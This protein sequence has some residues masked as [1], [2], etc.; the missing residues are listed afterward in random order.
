[1]NDYNSKEHPKSYRQSP[2][3]LAVPPEVTSGDRWLA[4]LSPAHRNEAKFFEVG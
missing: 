3:E 4:A 2:E 1:M